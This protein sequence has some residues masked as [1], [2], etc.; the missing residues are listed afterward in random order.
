M[1]DDSESVSKNIHT[2]LKNL[3][4]LICGVLFCI[5]CQRQ[6][7]FF[8]TSDASL[9][10]TAEIGIVLYSKQFFETQH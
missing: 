1:L 6:R 2:Y 10:Y 9:Y 5:R 8:I 3:S 4:H 7:T